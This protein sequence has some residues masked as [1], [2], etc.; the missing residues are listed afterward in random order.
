MRIGDTFDQPAWSPPGGHR[1]RQLAGLAV[2]ALP[3]VGLVLMVTLGRA[4]DWAMAMEGDEVIA[5]DEARRT[6][7]ACLRKQHGADL[8]ADAEVVQAHRTSGGM[9][10]DGTNWY[11]LRLPPGSVARIEA[12]LLAHPGGAPRSR[13]AGGAIDPVDVRNL[14]WQAGPPADARAYRFN[15]RNQT[16]AIFFGDHLYYR[17]WHF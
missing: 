16:Y 2:L 6:V 7:G 14:G 17:F 13:E 8:G 10:G 12:E 11:L 4:I 3:L 9:Q 5:A 15:D 1:R